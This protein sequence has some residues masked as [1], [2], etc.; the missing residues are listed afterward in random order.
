[1]TFYV[2]IKFSSLLRCYPKISTFQTS[3]EQNSPKILY[4][5]LTV[6]NQVVKMRLN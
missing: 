6:Y 5:E 3:S 2:Q 1:M 4:F